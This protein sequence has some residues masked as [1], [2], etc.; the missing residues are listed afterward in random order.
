MGINKTKFVFLSFA[1]FGEGLSGGDRIYIELARRWGNKYETTVCT[2]HE[3]LNMCKTQKL[4]ASKLTI[5]DMGPKSPSSN[6]FIHYLFRIY[7]GLR[8]AFT[9]KL[10][11]NTNTLVYSSSEFWMDSLPAAI[12]KIRFRK[13][14]WIA[15]WYQTAP[16][17]LKGF[18]EINREKFY[19][20]PALY[21]WFA[22]LPIKPLIKRYAD[23]V[24]VNNEDE[25][26]RFP[27]MDKKGSVIVL[28]GAVR[29]DQIKE[30]IYKHPDVRKVYDAVFQ[31][32]F[33]PQKGVVELIHIWKRIVK[34][35]PNA[36]LAMI[37]DGPLMRDVKT[38]IQDL[39]L[40]NNIKLFG[41]VFDG[42]KKYKI[43]S[44]S[45]IVV[46]PAFYDSGGMAS[47]EAMAFGLPAVGFNL[48][49]YDSYYPK[50]MIKIKTGNMD[51]FANQ[52]L[53]LLKD[54][55]K[56]VKIGREALEMIEENWSWEKRANEILE[57]IN[58]RTNQRGKTRL[59]KRR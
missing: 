42:P 37:G 6:F 55:K 28:I 39:G 1:S 56:R 34:V 59:G 20:L 8:F 36:Q 18:K 21:Y 57:Q 3:G 33:H 47:A 22:Q 58:K 41:Y 35:K 54:N 49:A 29:L 51:K 27:R 25:R 10:K 9:A 11:N 32:R 13:I 4:E 2:T 44:Q 45:K 48:K 5:K 43:F 30:Y 38:Q 23:K 17:P 12:L 46:H 50:G 31:G 53:I 26:K 52:I 14:Q 15:T 24:I 16:N 7:I 40:N 19:L